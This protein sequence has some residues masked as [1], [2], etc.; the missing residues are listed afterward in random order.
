MGFTYRRVAEAVGIDVSAFLRI[1]T[2]ENVPKRDTA[3]RIHTFYRG[4]IPLGVIH[5]PAHKSSIEWVKKPNTLA[6][7][8]TVGA[9]LVRE[10]PELAERIIER[11]VDPRR[12]RKAG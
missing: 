5:D 12:R 10:H 8:S 11:R 7:L 3:R 4:A 2:G 6:E 9:R 1:E